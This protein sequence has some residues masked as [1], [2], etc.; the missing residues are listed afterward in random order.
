MK[1]QDALDPGIEGVLAV[2]PE[3]F[4]PDRHRGPGFME[5][6]DDVKLQLMMLRNIVDLAYDNKVRLLNV[7]DHAVERYGFPVI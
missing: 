6:P 2:C 4:E 7:L 1:R 3:H 5:G